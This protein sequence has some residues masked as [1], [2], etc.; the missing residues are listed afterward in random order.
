MKLKEKILDYVSTAKNFL[1]EKVLEPSKKIIHAFLEKDGSKKAK[2][3]LSIIPEYTK[4][5]LENQALKKEH[6]FIRYL[7]KELFIYFIIAFSFFFLVFFVNQ[8]L[9]ALQDLL[10][11][12]VPLGKAMTL[13]FYSLP[14]V[15]AQS[16]PFGTLVGFLMCLGRIMSDNEILVLR[17]TGTSFF[18]LLIPV[19]AM[20]LVISIFSFFVNDYLLPAGN[21]KFRELTR[22]IKFSN[23]AALIEPNSIQRMNSG[24]VIFVIGDV[25]DDKISDIVVFDQDPEGRQRIIVGEQTDLMSPENRDVSMQLRL[26]YPSVVQFDKDKNSNYEYLQSDF[27]TLNMF[28]KSTDVSSSGSNPSEMTSTDLVRYIKTLRKNGNVSTYHLNSYRFEFHKRFAMPF[29]SLFFAF[30]AFPLSIL[31]GKNNGQTIGLIIGILI[32]VLYWTFM[33]L[34]FGFGPMKGWNPFIS[35]WGANIVLGVFALVFYLNLVKR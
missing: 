22:E 3:Y 33:M 30:L 13:M 20:G 24:Q 5:Y 19:I 1:N 32:S 28:E 18:Q 26:H 12:R 6:I 14:M 2:K 16:A 34:S 17:T 29:G 7:L 35:M 31:F 4:Q 25:T 21:L 15:I 11:K 27:L 8:I 9:L 10:S 23:P